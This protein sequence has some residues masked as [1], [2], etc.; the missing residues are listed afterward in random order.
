MKKSFLVITII[1]LFF[2]IQGCDR[3]PFKKKEPP[4][5]KAEIKRIEN[6]ELAKVILKPQREK[7]N[8]D[9]DPFKPITS[10]ASAVGYTP[11][12]ETELKNVKILGVTKINDEFRALLNVNDKKG[13]YKV[14][15]M[16]DQYK[17]TEIMKDQIMLSNGSQTITL[18]RGSSRENN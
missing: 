16:V 17:I 13:V 3:L 6:T 8:L 2:L 1:T 18:K 4:A 15:D 14:D 9:R 5:P 11:T 7:L 12:G 10:S